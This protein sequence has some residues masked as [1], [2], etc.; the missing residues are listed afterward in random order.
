MCLF[1]TAGLSILVGIGGLMVVG[2]SGEALGA[3]T[4]VA[5]P[6]LF[7]LGFGLRLRRGGRLLFWSI[8]VVQAL[9]LLQALGNLA[10]ADPR[11]LTQSVLPILTLV[12]VTRPQARE[13]LCR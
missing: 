5:L 1:I 4:W 12:F 8:I 3:M 2:F 9:I 10:A 13:R 11:A 6:G 7:C